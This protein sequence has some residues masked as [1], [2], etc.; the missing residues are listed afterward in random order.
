MSWAK[1]DRIGQADQLIDTT[2]GN[3]GPEAGATA[4][5][6]VYSGTTLKRT[7]AGLTGS[8]WTYPLGGTWRMVRSRTCAW[9]CAV[10][11]TASTLG[12]STTS[13]LNATASVSG[14]ARN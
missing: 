7:Y 13:R 11:A 8:S 9:F 14:W 6:Q 4:T 3:I 1:R 2:V 10:S 5:L 12:S